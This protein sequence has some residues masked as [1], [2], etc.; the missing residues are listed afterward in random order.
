MD[1]IPQVLV[2]RISDYVTVTDL[3]HTLTVSRNF[4]YAAERTSGVYN[5]FD[6][7]KANSGRF[8]ELYNGPRLGYLRHVKFRATLPR[9][10]KPEYE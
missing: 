4:Q 9:Y 2:D 10:E 5:E 3:K 1:S 7:T 6:L 8:F